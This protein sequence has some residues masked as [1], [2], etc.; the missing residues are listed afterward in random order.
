MNRTRALAVHTVPVPLLAL[1]ALLAALAAG[2][3]GSHDAAHAHGG[4]HATTAGTLSQAQLTFHDK[5]RKLWEDHVTWT[6]LA[7]VT[8]AAGP[9]ES[10]GATA[11]RLLQNQSDIGDAMKPFYGAEAGNQ[12]TELLNEHILVAVDVMTAAKKGDTAAFDAALAAWYVN[13]DEVA[14]HLSSLNPDDWPQDAMRQMMKGHL[15]QTLAE[16]AAELGGDYSGSVASYEEIHDHI[17][18]MA[19]ALSDGIM[20]DFPRRFDR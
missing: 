8:F 19:D 2:S 5:M 4:S 7:I 17:L 6:R 3:V 18:M 16:A 11:G 15:D 14:D 12:L 20:G 9:E 13:G 10:F 1:V